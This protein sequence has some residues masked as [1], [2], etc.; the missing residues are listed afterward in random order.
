M[1]NLPENIFNG[2]K[3]KG[4]NDGQRALLILICKKLK[5]GQHVQHDELI[6]IYKTKVQREQRCW[7]PYYDHEKEKWGHRYE[8]YTDYQI[9]SNAQNWLL[10]AL[11]ALIK[12]GYL[13]VL[14]R[15]DFSKIQEKSQALSHD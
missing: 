11:G 6:T 2:S 12:K 13:T 5:D 7:T 3:L 10:R 4:V 1:E 15:I 14:P 9:E 8:D